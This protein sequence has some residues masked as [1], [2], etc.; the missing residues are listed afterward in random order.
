MELPGPPL[1][2]QCNLCESSFWLPRKFASGKDCWIKLL[3]HYKDHGGDSN[4]RQKAQSF[5]LLCSKK[6]IMNLNDSF[7]R[8]CSH[9]VKC[10]L[11]AWNCD[12]SVHPKLGEIK[13]AYDADTD[14][15]EA[16]SPRSRFSEDSDASLESLDEDTQN[17][18]QDMT[19]K[20]AELKTSG[21]SQ[22]GVQAVKESVISLVRALAPECMEK[23]LTQLG[24]G[25]SFRESYSKEFGRIGLEEIPMRQLGPFPIKN[26]SEKTSLVYIVD[27]PEVFKRLAETC[28]AFNADL[29]KF[30]Q[31][32]SNG[33]RRGGG[34]FGV[35]EDGKF[36]THRYPIEH[37]MHAARCRRHPLFTDIGWMPMEGFADGIRNTKYLEK[38]GF[39]KNMMIILVSLDRADADRTKRLPDK[40]GGQ[41]GRFETINDVKWNEKN[42]FP[43]AL[44][45]KQVWT[46]EFRADFF[47]EIACMFEKASF[48]INGILDGKKTTV[49]M[50][51]RICSFVADHPA[52]CEL[53]NVKSHTGNRSCHMCD[54]TFP[55]AMR[56]ENE[57]KKR[58][59]CLAQPSTFFPAVTE[60]MFENRVREV[61]AKMDQVARKVAGATKASLE[62]LQAKYG[63]LGESPLKHFKDF[64]VF[65]DCSIDF[66]HNEFEGIAYETEDQVQ[67]WFT[68]SKIVLFSSL[69]SFVRDKSNYEAHQE[70]QRF[71]DLERSKDKKE[72]RLKAVEVR[73][74]MGLMIKFVRS[75][76]FQ[77]AMKAQGLDPNRCPQIEVLELHHAYL[78]W[79]EKGSFSQ[80]DLSA[81]Q[82]MTD[83]FRSKFFE[84]FGYMIPKGHY[85]M[86]YK[87]MIEHFGPLQHKWCF[88]YESYNRI[89]V[90]I[91]RSSNKKSFHRFGTEDLA[92]HCLS[93][94]LKEH[95]KFCEENKKKRKGRT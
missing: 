92:R 75:E 39:T 3:N 12:L 74:M 32:R 85:T 20:L 22:K 15:N 64:C 5:Q 94:W 87:A 40:R 82:T 54:Y 28:P 93:L 44:V 51:P 30:V 1:R 11:G 33:L 37:N 17:A 36:S 47:K 62:A 60:T 34:E 38:D 55:S 24:D 90:K 68:G 41:T 4:T 88:A 45:S 89:A 13:V 2:Y 76:P 77:T 69:A 18:C 49:E 58:M 72:M 31:W 53:M 16:D 21:A 83:N 50:K 63:I 42:I 7:Q 10:K 25:T 66:M 35:S 86:H 84:V 95:D 91:W 61:D 6:P 73:H 65:T 27:I 70:Y 14:N 56:D 52:K 67:R 81:L 19:A 48:K 26:S 46:A 29:M 23:V 71:S 8:Y 79:L 78:S 59:E 57:R 9:A 80:D 43:V